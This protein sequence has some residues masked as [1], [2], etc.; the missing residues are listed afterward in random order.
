MACRSVLR[1]AMVVQPFLQ[2]P[3]DFYFN[4]NL[5]HIPSRYNCKNLLRAI[6]ARQFHPPKPAL[7]CSHNETPP[8]HDDQDQDP[9]QQAVLKAISG[10]FNKFHTTV[11]FPFSFVIF[12]E[13]GNLLLVFPSSNEISW[14]VTEVSKTEGRVGQATNMVIGGTVA[15]DSTNEWLALDQK[16]FFNYHFV[17][18]VS[19]FHYL[20]PQKGKN[21][22]WLVNNQ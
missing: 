17:F 22:T 16:V 18:I 4:V 7:S 9:P 20:F 15:H 11:T 8:S 21:N 1:S 10:N 2:R 5:Y 3:R 6:G 12:I 14:F 19:S 13:V